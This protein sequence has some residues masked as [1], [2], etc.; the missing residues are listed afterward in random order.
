M[1]ITQTLI[2]LFIDRF[3]PSADPVFGRVGHPV[4]WFGHIITFMEERLN[5]PALDAKTRK[6]NGITMLAVLVLVALVAGQALHQFCA[7]FPFGWVLEGL[8]A[9]VFLAH[10]ELKEAVIKVSQSLSVSLDEGRSAVGHIVGRDTEAM[11][12]ADVSRAAIESLAEN[13]SDGVIAP[14]FWMALLGLPGI[15]AYKAINTADSMVGHLN[16]RYTDFGWASAKFDD[17]VNWLPARLTALLYAAACFIVSDADA[18]KS[19]DSAIKDAPKHASPNAGWPEAAMAGAL[20]FELGGPR[21]Y[22]G[23]ILNLP[24]MGNGERDLNP[25]HIRKAAALFDMMGTCAAIALL[26]VGILI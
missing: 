3:G 14:L 23:S 2:A 20:N 16:E 21:A 1:F 7:L 11:D 18:K 9:S 19:W 10:R 13:S 5:N 6:N 17:L 22:R 12:Q 24:T 25:K 26:G 4:V 15:I 8:I